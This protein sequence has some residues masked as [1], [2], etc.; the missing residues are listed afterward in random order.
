MFA[1][2]FAKT[3]TFTRETIL[4][5]LHSLITFKCHWHLAQT[6]NVIWNNKQLNEHFD[7]KHGF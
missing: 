2:R 5:A 3:V 1:Y 6:K 4:I 7:H